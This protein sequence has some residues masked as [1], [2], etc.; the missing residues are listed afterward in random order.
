VGTLQDNTSWTPGY[1]AINYTI[2]RFADVLLMAAEAEWEVGSP[3]R[4]RELVNFVRER[5]ADPAG[6]VM[7]GATPAA[8]YQISQYPGP[9]SKDAAALE[10]IRFERKLELSSEGHRFYDLARW[11]GLYGATTSTPEYIND[12]LNAYLQYEAPKLPSGAFTGATFDEKDK[13]LPLPQGQ[14][15]LIGPDILVQNPNY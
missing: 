5:A 6:F 4:A 3:E 10:R 15:D 12:V 7:K 14:I 2:I 1:T 8:D 13:W 9:W 11:S